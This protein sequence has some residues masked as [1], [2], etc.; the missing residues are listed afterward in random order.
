VDPID[1]DT[2]AQLVLGRHSLRLVALSACNSAQAGPG[3][4]FAGV[5]PALVQKRVPA[6]VAMQYPTVL[7]ETA[8]KFATAFYEALALGRP[9]DVAVNQ[10]RNRL[11]LLSL[12]ARDWST[13]VL[14]LGTRSFRVLDPDRKEAAEAGQAGQWLQEAA[15]NPNA[16][17]ALS[18]L[19]QRLHEVAARHHALEELLALSRLLARLRAEFEPCRQRAEQVQADPIQLDTGAL[20]AEWL[21]VR[22]APLKQLE[23]FAGRHPGVQQ[24]DWYQELMECKITIEAALP[25]QDNR[26]DLADAV[27]KLGSLLQEGE[28]DV[29]RRAEQTVAALVAFSD[30]A[31]VP[32]A[33]PG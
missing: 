6:V 9:V 25:P 27:P 28:E 7:Q 24:L 8:G 13:P 4:V 21:R 15:G 19:G 18:Q 17:A 1:A 29:G 10:A 14:Y 20:K 30:Q 31:L 12:A 2:F 33:G 22:N 32:V 26:G 23:E 5:G 16:R 3:G 11:S